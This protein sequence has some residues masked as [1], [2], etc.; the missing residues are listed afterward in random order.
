[1][2]VYG[3]HHFVHF[4]L[5]ALR[6]RR[7]KSE[8]RLDWRLCFDTFDPCYLMR[9][10]KDRMRYIR[11]PHVFTFRASA[12]GKELRDSRALGILFLPGDSNCIP[13]AAA[14][15]YLLQPGCANRS[16]GGAPIGRSNG[17]KRR[18]A[19]NKNAKLVSIRT[20]S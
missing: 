3:S 13:S 19:R 14:I 4:T 1:M 9:L 8:A 6:S 16:R 7:S 10:N 2:Y 18:K 15:I 5:D 17:L 11:L 20:A 12:V